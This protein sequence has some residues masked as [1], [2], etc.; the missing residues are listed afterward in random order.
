MQNFTYQLAKM[1]LLS[2]LLTSF[3]SCSKNEE[4]VVPDT[5][6]MEFTVFT[7]AGHP[8]VGAVI[9]LYDSRE[10]WAEGKEEGL[11]ATATADIN[12]KSLITHL[13]PKKY[14]YSITHQLN[15]MLETNWEGNFTTEE[16]ITELAL[17]KETVVLNESNF[18]YLIGE[19]IKW[20]LS[21][22]YV[23][24]TAFKETLDIC[25]FESFVS[26]YKNKEVIYNE[27]QTKC[28]EGLPQEVRSTFAVND[29][30]L[31]TDA[32]VTD[33]RLK[34]TVAYTIFQV[35]NQRLDLIA[36]DEEGNKYYLEYQAFYYNF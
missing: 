29:D 27:G 32:F 17:N 35:Y 13:E 24:E 21:D 16:I 1:M 2:A 28:E 8:A 12:G 18:N 19:N 11:V 26:F 5:T 25:L 36:Q 14:F 10:A 9:S 23:N 6:T 15:H 33:D 34:G 20:H 31:L 22:I 30:V 4:E 7:G 3:L